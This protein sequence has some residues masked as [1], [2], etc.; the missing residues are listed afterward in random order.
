MATFDWSRIAPLSRLPK[1]VIGVL[2]EIAR[3]LLRRPVVGIC[4][5]AHTAD[6][7]ILLVRRSDTGTWALPGGTL[8]WGEQLATA[9]PREIEE[10]TG[11]RWVGMERV[12]GIYSRPDRDLRFHAVTVCVVGEVAE[13]IAGPHNLV[14]ISEAR[15]FQP[16]ELPSPLAMGMSDMLDHALR[17]DSDVVLE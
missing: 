9:L 6:G 2:Y 12:S 15:L 17:G 10:E 4:A 11:A 1:G 5:V 3:H 16:A 7:R 14:E 13:P 8:E